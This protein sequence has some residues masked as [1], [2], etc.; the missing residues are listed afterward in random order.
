M[1]AKLKQRFIIKKWNVRGFLTKK[2]KILG[3]LARK[4]VDKW[5]IQETKR[6][7]KEEFCHGYRIFLQKRPIQYNE[8]SFLVRGATEIVGSDVITDRICCLI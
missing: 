8:Q 3:F 1:A 4:Q 2:E 6:D 5:G 7:A